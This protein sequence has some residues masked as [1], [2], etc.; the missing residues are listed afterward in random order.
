MAIKFGNILYWISCIIAVALCSWVSYSIAAGLNK[1]AIVPVIG[2]AFVCW[3][4]GRITKFALTG[5]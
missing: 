5:K 2:Y 1:Q 4:I 3:L